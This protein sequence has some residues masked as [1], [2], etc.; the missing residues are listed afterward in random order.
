MTQIV[1]RVDASARIGTGHL[2]R[3]LAL[4]E[5]LRERG[6][7]VRFVCRE[8]PG[9]L[10]ALLRDRAF[11]VSM[12]PAP[13]GDQ[14]TGGED[15]AA[16]LGAR[17]EADAA[18]TILVLKGNPDW[19]V[20]DHYGIGIEWERRLRPHV[21]KL[22]AIDDLANR[23]HD[24]DALLDQNYS[25]TGDARYAGL[26]AE[27]SRLLTGPRYALLADVYAAY[28]QTQR[29]PRYPPR[30][31]LLFF[32]GS[33]PANAT[34]M[35]L[36]AMS[37]DG[38]RELHVDIVVGRNYPHSAALREQAEARPRTVVHAPQRHLADL[39]AQ[40]DFAIG[41]GGAT[42]WER[43]CLG[44]PSILVSIAD[45]QRP[46]CE[47]LA[48]AGLAKYVGHYP[49]TDARNLA[50]V[51]EQLVGDPHTLRELGDKGRHVA[52]GLG[53]GRVAEAML[54]SRFEDTRMRP[55]TGRAELVLEACGVPLGS[56][57]WAP[58]GESARIDWALDPVAL[59]RG[60]DARLVA[61]GIDL[62]RETAGKPT[63][64]ELRRVQPRPARRSIAVLS[65]ESSWMNEH[66]PALLLRWLEAG[67]RVLWTHERAELPSGDFCFLLG[68]G[69]VV[70]AAALARFRH[71]LVVHE[72]D[73]PRGRGWSPMTWQIL[74][75]ASRIPV[76]LLEAS[77]K[78]DA[79][80][81]YAQEWV[82]FEGHE[83]V[84]ELRAA[85]GRSAISLCALFVDEFPAIIG[86]A[87]AQ[88]GDATVYR[89]RMPAD[90]RLD[91]ERSLASQF[92][93]LRVVDAERYPGFFEHR[94][95]RYLVD[96]RKA[97]K[98]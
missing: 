37:G 73:L 76:T 50:K 29:P 27:A 58:T 33:D 80:A 26:V 72:S 57:H 12:L 17:P 60:W 43:M 31:A 16:W 2:M 5:A 88:S 49:G 20:V 62:M 40:A 96:V 55:G 84:Q 22:L 97:G 77:E 86:R 19:L 14:A 3:C 64:V 54:P 28:R 94:G 39:M 47:A 1:F 7:Q 61:R 82:E 42:S 56:L 90:S 83:L 78:V 32:G 35:A 69:Q 79:G 15:Y 13:V 6:A 91:A 41:A 93:L 11:P 4:A 46:A 65:D 70:P 36:E 9:H 18:E 63:Y 53:A 45:N 10:A 68:C 74:E 85:I 95:Q 30:R 34:G 92:D 51:V 59:G 75:G 52:D 23:P 21:G 89:R 71:S 67:H 87:R 8:H 48:T 81:V 25:A 38:L 98:P 24:C 66:I 44:L